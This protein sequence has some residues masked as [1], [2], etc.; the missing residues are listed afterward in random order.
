MYFSGGLVPTYLTMK[1][2]HLINT[3]WAV[4][5]PGAMSI[6][7]VIVMRTYFTQPDSRRTA[8]IG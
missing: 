1:E 4:T 8:G 3:V 7:N 5:L 2:L 6:S